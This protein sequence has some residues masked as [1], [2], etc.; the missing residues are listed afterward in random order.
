LS[1]WEFSTS[2]KKIINARIQRSYVEKE[3]CGFFF[4]L[5]QIMVLLT[6]TIQYLAEKPLGLFSN[7]II[8]LYQGQHHFKLDLQNAL[9]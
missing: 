6:P 1:E 3:Q 7:D 2:S 4:G 9:Q 8:N 5:F